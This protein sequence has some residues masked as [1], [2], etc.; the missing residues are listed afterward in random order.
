MSKSLRYSSAFRTGIDSFA[1][2]ASSS[3]IYLSGGNSES[4]A[5]FQAWL[6]RIGI[7]KLKDQFFLELFLSSNVFLYR[8]D[9]KMTQEGAKKMKQAYSKAAKLD[10]PLRYILLNPANIAVFGDLNFENPIY[11][12]MLNKFEAKLL[13]DSSDEESK[14]VYKNL[15]A[16]IKSYFDGGVAKPVPLDSSKLHAVFYKKQDYKPFGVPMGFCVLDSIELKLAMQKADLAMSK[17]LEYAMLVVTMG[18]PRAEGGTNPESLRLLQETFSSNNIGRVLISDYT[19]EAKFVIPELNKVYG[20]D[21]YKIVN[22]DISAGLMNIF[23]STDTATTGSPVGKLKIFSEKVNN[24]QSIFINEFLLPEIKRV[25]KLMGFKSYPIPSMA[26]I[27]LDDQ[28]QMMRVYTQLIQLGVLTPKDGIE[29]IE[30]GIFP[31]YDDLHKNQELLKVDKEKGLFQPLQGGPFSQMEIAKQNQKGALDLQ[32]TSQESAVEQ[33]KINNQHDIKKTKMQHEH[34]IVN[35]KPE[36]PQVHLNMP[37]KTVKPNPVAKPANIKKV[38]GPVGRPSGAKG[39]VS[40]SKLIDNIKIHSD[41][42]STVTKAYKKSNK[43][44]ELT[45]IDQQNIKTLV[46][47]ISENEVPNEWVAKASEYVKEPKLPD[48]DR[49]FDIS[50]ISEHYGLSE[51]SAAIVYHSTIEDE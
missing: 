13:K 4:L 7:N 32:K 47:A 29:A 37:G 26:R 46:T 49:I 28:S 42:I 41:L 6:K 17:M 16:A 22:E 33:L 18:A 31:D 11:Y 45:D 34:D 38:T 20:A 1:E 44:K 39:S 23:F 19:T 43:I 2:L 8:I 25:S 3:N 51:E 10:I 21:K 50:E 9:G 36:A 5:F 35:P 27:D 15:P 48:A 14:E 40:M 24:A 12:R 30:K